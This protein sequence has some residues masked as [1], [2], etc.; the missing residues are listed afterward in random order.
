MSE[1]FLLLKDLY[2][3]TTALYSVFSSIDHV[4]LPHHT[5]SSSPKK[6]YSPSSS[7]MAPWPPPRDPPSPSSENDSRP[8]ENGPLVAQ[9]S[10][11][12]LKRSIF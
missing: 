6:K 9:P 12:D 8:P 7:P 4:L 11:I 5:S 3:T 2:S 1:T 10:Q